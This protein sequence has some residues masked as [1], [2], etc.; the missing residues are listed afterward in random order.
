MQDYMPQKKSRELD[1]YCLPWFKMKPFEREGDSEK[2]NSG[3][4][5]VLK[6]I[7]LEI[8]TICFLCKGILGEK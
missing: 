6:F 4:G 5:G 8:L 1:V 2:K 3:G 7:C